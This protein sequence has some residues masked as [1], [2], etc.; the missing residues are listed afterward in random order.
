VEVIFEYSLLDMVKPMAVKSIN[1]TDMDIR[2]IN[3]PRIIAFLS[4]LTQIESPLQQYIWD[5]CSAKISYW[6][7]YQPYEKLPK[8]ER[9]KHG[10]TIY[11][12]AGLYLVPE[13]PN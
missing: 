13:F 4:K 11:M 1:L 10:N 2:S 5:L 3:P 6:Y 7:R 12:T 9:I 8:G